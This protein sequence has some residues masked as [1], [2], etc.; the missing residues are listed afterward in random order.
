MDRGVARGG[1]AAAVAER[2]VEEKVTKCMAKLE[3]FRRITEHGGIR[4]FG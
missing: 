3:G 4:G 2:L 1:E